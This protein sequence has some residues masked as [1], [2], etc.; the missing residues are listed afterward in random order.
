MVQSNYQTS[1][2]FLQ[3][4]LP[5]G[6][7]I[8]TAISL[9]KKSIETRTFRDPEEVRKWLE[10]V[11]IDRNTYFSVNSCRYDVTKKPMREDVKSL[12]WL[13]VDIDPRSGEDLTAERNRALKL[14][15]D[16]PNGIPK[17]TVIVFSG[18][19][20][21][22]F[23]RL[24][25]PMEINGEEAIYQSAKRYN[26]AL[27]LAFGADECHNVDRIMRL[28]GTIN[29]PDER[30]KK[31]GRVEVLAELV[32]WIDDRVYPLNVF[33]QAPAVQLDTKGFGHTTQL[34]V[35]GNIKRVDDVQELKGISDLCKIVIVQGTD[36]DRPDRFPSRSEAIFFVC[37]EMVRAD[38]DNDTIYSVIT[39]PDFRISSS[40]L[41][42]GRNAEGYA[43]RQIERAR[44]NAI[45]PHLRE[46]N[47][48]YAVVSYGGKMRVIYEDWDE[49]LERQRL[50]K[51]TFEDFCRK[52]M[53]RRVSIGTDAQGNPRY[54]PLGKWWL[55]HD[56]RRE[57]EK[58]TFAPGRETPNAYNMWRGFAFEPTAGNLHQPLLDHVFENVC[59]G[60]QRSYEYLMGWMAW[61]V[62]HPDQPGQTAIVLRGDQGVGKGFLA[63]TFGRLFGRHFIHV[64]NALHLT[65]NFNFHLRDCAV[66]FADE[67]FYAGDRK[68]ASTLK[69]LVTEDSIMVEPKGVDTEMAP[70]CLHIIMASNDD[71][72]VPAGIK[73]RRFCVLD[74]KDAHIQDS[75][76]FGAIS[77]AMRNGGYSNF[78][79]TLMTYDL[80]KFDVR[81][82]PQTRALQDQKIHSF[83]PTH[84]WWFGKLRDG[85]LLVEH[86]GWRPDVVVEELTADFIEH[87]R[88]WGM[89]ARRSSATKLGHFL[90]TACPND[91]L[92]RWQSREPMTINDKLIQR[93]YYYT[94]PPLDVLRRHWDERFGGPYTW[95][96]IE[97]DRDTVPF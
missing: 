28:P 47:E 48:K 41:D 2:E 55:E 85:R 83:E 67:A 56:K 78:L 42:K 53:N 57:Y 4:W 87:L 3:R 34:Q 77:A 59:S 8:L 95:P 80:S 7:W 76:Y 79:H 84:D 90:V 46:M 91:S 62:Q 51:M 50:V 40:V 94:F 35:S 23:W 70:N 18:G 61:A 58:V 14:L 33:S 22:G 86:G 15:Q 16:P 30:K 39:D 93:P 29:R 54:A 6:P 32:E 21:Q 31:K 71:W 52:H 97:K 10:R 96:P 5:G 88:V 17:P 24:Q 13:H 64:S 60:D 65:G 37:C 43:K 69:T 73:E 20:Y 36:P 38:L 1:L 74:V 75:G 25:E 44:E 26:Q 82:V 27:E 72:V 12:D 66:L 49:I 19:G 81:N 63:R 11:G 45:D 92:K 9:D 89:M 68:H